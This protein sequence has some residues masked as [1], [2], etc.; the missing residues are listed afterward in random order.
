MAT[1]LPPLRESFLG[2]TLSLSGTVENWPA[3]QT[4]EISFGG[5]IVG[6]VTEDGRFG[7]E[8]KELPP[9]TGPAVESLLPLPVLAEQ[10]GCNS[11]TLFTSDPAA[12]VY[13]SDRLELTQGG[14]SGL[15]PQ[16]SPAVPFPALRRS[17]EWGLDWDRDKP[18]LA[19]VY[20]DRDV[21]LS[22]WRVC[23]GT[24]NTAWHAPGPWRQTALVNVQ[25]RHGWNDVTMT[26]R[27]LGQEN[28]E[29]TVQGSDTRS[30]APWW[31]NG[32][33]FFRP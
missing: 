7:V 4:A 16:L 2:E 32:V 5:K 18:L 28:G 27:E 15:R 8:A 30:A 10:I 19:L 14:P 13:W 9:Y 20:A 3:G 11:G 26:Y 25:L 6:S 24:Y 33:P 29:L 21:R 1:A 17:P 22:G 31:Y 12:R 23:T